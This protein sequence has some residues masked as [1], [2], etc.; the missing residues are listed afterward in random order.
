MRRGLLLKGD[1]GCPT[2]ESWAVGQIAGWRGGGFPPAHPVWGRSP[3]GCSSRGTRRVQEPRAPPGLCCPRQPATPGLG[4][5]QG[6][7]VHI[8]VRSRVLPCAWQATQPQMRKFTF[9]GFVGG[10]F[11]A[12]QRFKPTLIF[13]FK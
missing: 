4:L 5:R 2:W 3:L 9:L 13:F 7:T 12:H 10:S 11:L 8:G 6:T 1:L